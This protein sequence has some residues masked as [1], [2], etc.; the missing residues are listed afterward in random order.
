MKRR[1]SYD[2]STAEKRLL[3]ACS[4]ERDTGRI[5]GGEGDGPQVLGFDVVQVRLA[6]AA[7]HHGGLARVC[8]NKVGNSGGALVD[9]EIGVKS[10]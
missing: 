3:G 7:G 10:Q 2:R 8:R 1:R 4:G 9:A 6:G 5:G